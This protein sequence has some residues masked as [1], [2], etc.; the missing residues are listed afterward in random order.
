MKSKA[1]G[2][3]LIQ[4]TRLGAFN[5]YL[6]REDDGFTLIDTGMPGSASGILAAAWKHGAPIARIAITHAH[7]DHVGSL[8]ALHAVL[9]EAEIAI[10]AREARF[11]SGDLS[12]DPG[13]PQ[14][15]PRA[16]QGTGHTRPT[17]LLEDGDTLGSLQVLVVPGHTPG[18]VAFFDPR[19]GTLI[20]G[21]AM[22]TAGGVAVAGTPRPLFP[23]PATATWHK[24]TALQ[25]AR[26]MRALEP[27]R[28]ATGHG[29][30]LNDPLGAMDRAIRAAG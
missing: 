12:L 20:V 26:R 7:S 3:R 9:P 27:T 8:D 5:C 28:L 24:P 22:Q 30:V 11:M 6:V 29:P 16:M 13:E 10:G 23:F 1:H 2:E 19:D 21:D 14:V 18:H 25:S 17:R 4:L 15:K